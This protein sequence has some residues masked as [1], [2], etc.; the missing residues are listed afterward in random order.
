MHFSRKLIPKGKFHVTCKNHYNMIYTVYIL[1]FRI[2][3]TWVMETEVPSLSTCVIPLCKLP[4]DTVT[5][6]HPSLYSQH[7]YRKHRRKWS[8]ITNTKEDIL[9]YVI[10][11]KY[12][13]IPLNLRDLNRS[14]QELMLLKKC[15]EVTI[16]DH[17]FLNLSCYH[18]EK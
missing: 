7:R 17:V 6:L 3:D 4:R 1:C 8:Y 13:K 11:T 16:I 9:L 2:P 10:L 15:F 14:L 12:F 5:S 18:T